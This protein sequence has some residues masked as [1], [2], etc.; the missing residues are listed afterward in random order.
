MPVSEVRHRGTLTVEFYQCNIREKQA[1][2]QRL[3]GS[4]C[5]KCRDI[6]TLKVKIALSF[7]P[8][9]SPWWGRDSTDLVRSR[10]GASQPKEAS[11]HL[12]WA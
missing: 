6:A 11:G 7:Q 8:T 12:P 4:K 2:V 5:K 9:A 1:C 3:L 10:S